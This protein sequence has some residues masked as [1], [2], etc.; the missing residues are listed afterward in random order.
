MSW[1]YWIERN[2]YVGYDDFADMVIIHF[3][4][5]K[6]SNKSNFQDKKN[7]FIC[8]WWDNL[9]KFDKY[10]NKSRLARRINSN[11][12]ILYHHYERRAKT[13]NYKPNTLEIKE[14]IAEF[15]KKMNEL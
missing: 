13:T 2:G 9:S 10:K 5:G 1:G 3:E 4:L 15:E 7:Y 6:K 14:Y 11:H 12:S 8:W